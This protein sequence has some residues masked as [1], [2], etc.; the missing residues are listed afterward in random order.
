MPFDTG[1]RT[2][3]RLGDSCLII[4]EIR[5]KEAKVLYEAMRVGAMSNVVAGTIHADNPYGVFDRVVNDLDVPRGSFKVTD[6]IIIVNQ[7]KDP[8]GL[9]RVRR[10]FSVTE[11][12]KNWEHEPEFQ[13]LLVY[14]PQS[15]M[16][17]PTDFLMKG[18]SVVL[19]QILGR[20]RGY[21]NYNDM[22]NDIMLRSWSKE[23]L[24][25]IGTKEEYEA[26]Y[27]AKGNIIF[28]KLFNQILPL[29]SKKNIDKF[30]VQYEKELREYLLETRKLKKHQTKATSKEEE[31][32]DAKPKKVKA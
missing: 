13:D 21:K 12:L 11:V 3:L 29:Q 28:T 6:L 24:V 7:I 31:K 15:D 18:K 4:G 26:E 32:E 9:T 20:T 23:L 17:E 16:L 25:K 22:L 19:N 1:L 14:N 10:V 2:S 30:K 27:I 8:T 5:S